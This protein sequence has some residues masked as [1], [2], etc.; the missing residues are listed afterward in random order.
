M[1]HNGVGMMLSATFENRKGLGQVCSLASLFF[2]IHLEKV[3]RHGK[4][5]AQSQNYPYR[6]TNCTLLFADDYQLITET[7]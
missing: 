2:K 6:M 7:T 1:E 3:W 5:N 4:G